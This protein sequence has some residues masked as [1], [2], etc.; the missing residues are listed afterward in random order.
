[1]TS[2]VVAPQPLTLFSFGYEGWGSRTQTLVETVDAVEAARGFAPPLFVDARLRR[3]V[4]AIGFR[5]RNFEKLL[6]PD[7]HCWLRGLGNLAVLDDG[8]WRLKDP[9]EVDVLLTL[10][11]E[12]AARRRRVIFVCSCGQPPTR[13]HRHGLVAKQLV[14]RAR[15][16]GIDATVSEWPG[17]EPARL[18]RI[19]DARTLRAVRA[20]VLRKPETGAPPP[21]VT[22]ADP[23]GL[24]GIA[25]GSQ[26]TVGDGVGS[27]DV[28]IGPPT[29]S[30]VGWHVPIL[31]P[32]IDRPAV[33]R[34]RRDNGYGPLHSGVATVDRPWAPESVYTLLHADRVD[35][36]RAEA[37][38]RFVVGRRM[39]TA[40]KLFSAAREADQELAVVIGDAV[41]CSAVIAVARLV[42][43]T[44][45]DDGSELLIDR[46]R[47][48]TPHRRQQE[49]KLLS[50]GNG[51]A[52]GFIRPYALVKTP[53][54]V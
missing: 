52:A 32:A 5:E 24:H 4:R 47:P 9:A 27:I 35:A 37:T 20:A 50:T 41:D 40:Q 8:P 11:S 38:L 6:G 28:L 54:W 13:C 43:L 23:A 36:A 53:A 42:E 25:W 45:H 12:S 44:L 26:L 22:F 15:A 14:A 21:T 39:T 3:A 51:I 34:L 2:A 16:Q 33:D 10:A 18:E 17:G 30:K 7:R 19:V 31:G 49:L 1:M 46:L 29:A 48:L